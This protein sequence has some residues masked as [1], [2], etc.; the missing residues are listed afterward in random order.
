MM[1]LS[2]TMMPTSRGS[3]ESGLV[4]DRLGRPWDQRRWARDSAGRAG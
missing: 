3:G 4:S 2:S 1:L